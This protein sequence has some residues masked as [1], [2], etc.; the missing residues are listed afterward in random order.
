M[1]DVARTTLLLR[2]GGLLPSTDELRR[3]KITELRYL[4]C[5]AYLEYYTQI[6]PVSRR[7]IARWDPA[8]AADRLTEGIDYDEKTELLEFIKASFS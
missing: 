5:E 2:A 4:F 3:Q 8:V 1:A 6:Y 7:M